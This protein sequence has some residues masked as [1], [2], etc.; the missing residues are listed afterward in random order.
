MT[1]Y[2]DVEHLFQIRTSEQFSPFYHCLLHYLTDS[3]LIRTPSVMQL[4]VFGAAINF[5]AV[6]GKANLK[7]YLTE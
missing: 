1:E 6:S 7:E 4:K 2:F 3:N 5:L